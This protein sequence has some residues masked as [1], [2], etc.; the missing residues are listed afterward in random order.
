MQNHKINLSQFLLQFLL[1][2]G[3]ATMALRLSLYPAIGG[4]SPAPC[5]PWL[6]NGITVLKQCDFLR[7]ITDNHK[8]GGLCCALY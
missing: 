1:R 5:F 7:S 2:L 4:F 3:G 8:G 6:G